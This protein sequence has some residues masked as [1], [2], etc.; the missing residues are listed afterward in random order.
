MEFSLTGLNN[1]TYDW[2]ANNRNV[3]DVLLINKG[4]HFENASQ[5]WNIPQGG[6]H[7][8]V[9]RADFNNDGKQDLFVHRY[10]YLKERVADL[11]LLNTGEGFELL[12]AHGAYDVNDT[13]H[14]DMGQAFDFNNDGLLDMLNGSEDT[15]KWYLYV[16]QAKNAGNY[17]QFQVGYSPKKGV[18]PLSAEVTIETEDGKRFFQTV[19]STGEV[20]SQSV[21]NT[22]HFGLAKRNKIK[23][24]KIVWRNGE[25]MNFGSL[26]ANAKYQSAASH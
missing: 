26:Q 6:N 14:G 10:G 25:V 21:I 23:S 12:T 17:I 2:P 5:A 11:L 22:V 15:G 18:D 20:H 19:G 9:S 7:W 8:G 16:N 13:G 24:A 4:T 1:V 3:Q